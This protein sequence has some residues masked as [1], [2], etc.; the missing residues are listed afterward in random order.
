MHILALACT[1][2]RV[3]ST[4]SLPGARGA[5]CSNAAEKETTRPDLAVNDTQTLRPDQI[6]IAFAPA[7]AAQAQNALLRRHIVHVPV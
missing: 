6:A 5:Q 7:A 4:I 2:M 1:R 3:L